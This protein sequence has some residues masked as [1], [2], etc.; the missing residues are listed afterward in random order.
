MKHIQRV[1]SEPLPVP[2]I[3][4]A[5]RPLKPAIEAEPAGDPISDVPFY[6][7]GPMP[8][9]CGGYLSEDFNGR[10]FCRGCEGTDP[11]DVTPRLPLCRRAVIR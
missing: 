9:R 1:I 7:P 8:C 3:T 2:V 4:P 6:A 5:V 10:L 11:A